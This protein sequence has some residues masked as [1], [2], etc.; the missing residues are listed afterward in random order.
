MGDTDY[1]VCDMIC[2]T[3]INCFMN[4][5][6]YKALLTQEKVDTAMLVD[7]DRAMREYYNKPI[8]DGGEDQIIKW[9]TS[10]KK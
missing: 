6:P 2:D 7:R 3:A 1:F 9:G 4:G 5:N 10:K 8:Q